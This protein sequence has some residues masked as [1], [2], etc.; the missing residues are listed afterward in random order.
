MPF[1]KTTTPSANE[2]MLS[3]DS[4]TVS[5]ARS[6]FASLSIVSTSSAESDISPQ[7][8]PS[9]NVNHPLFTATCASSGYVRDALSENVYSSLSSLNARQRFSVWAANSLVAGFSG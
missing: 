7:N 8:A 6:A 1:S 5:F 3:A 2:N 9:F 4:S